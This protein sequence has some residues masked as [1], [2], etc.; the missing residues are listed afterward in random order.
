MVVEAILSAGV[1]AVCRELTAVGLVTDC[2]VP[3]FFDCSQ[4]DR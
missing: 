2:A 4:S 1:D 3:G